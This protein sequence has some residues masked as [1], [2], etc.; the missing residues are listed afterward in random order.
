LAGGIENVQ[1]LDF[2]RRF[3]RNRPAMQIRASYFGA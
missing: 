2:I 3:Q 1:Y